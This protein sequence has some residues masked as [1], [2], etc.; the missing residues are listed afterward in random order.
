MAGRLAYEL[1]EPIGH[2]ESSEVFRARGP[3][4]NKIAVKLIAGDEARR[5][6]LLDRL[7]AEVALSRRLGAA[8]LVALL[9]SGL[10]SGRPFL[11]MELIEG[12][13]LAAG[14]A[15]GPMPVRR[16][17]AVTG[18]VAA[19]LDAIHRAGAVHR[20]VKPGNVMLRSGDVPVLMDLGVAALGPADFRPGTE[21]VGSPGF[22]APEVIDDRPFDGKADVFALGVVLYMLL[23]GTRPFDGT[24]EQVMRAIRREEPPPPSTL[25]SDLPIGVDRIVARALAKD[26]ARRSSAADLA[27]ALMQLL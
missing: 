26:P 23:T 10:L 5:P 22:L 8:G 11:A 20:D 14:M 25:A 12:T 15:A 18:A 2:G 19:T 4:G 1:L 6:G 17:L 16:S 9:D 24:M 3:D 21:L 13:T 27:L 7:A